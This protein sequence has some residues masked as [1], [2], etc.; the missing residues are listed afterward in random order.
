MKI[1]TKHL[2]RYQQIVRLLWKYGRSDLVK[3]LDD[4]SFAADTPPA[5]ADRALPD[6]LADD[7]E[8]MGPTYVKLGQVLSSR[9]D[10]IPATY[11]DALERLQDRVK[12]FSDAEA[13]QIIESELGAR[14]S[15]AFSRFDPEPIA[16]ASLGQVHRAALR[17]GR[18]VVVKVQRPN[19]GP[20]IA[21]DFE[22]LAQMSAFLDEHSDWARRRRLGQIV[23]ELR[24]SVLHELDYEREAQSMRMMLKNIEGFD[25]LY[26]PQP[27]DDYCT[28]RV[29]TMEY[30]AGTKITEL[31]P[32][33][34]MELNGAELAEQLFKAY[35]K[36]VLV[37]GLFHADPHPGNIFV[38]QDGHLVML[39][40]GMVG[41]VTPGM[42]EKLLKLLVAVS[43]GKSEQATD[44]V[45]QISEVGR[46]CDK[47][48]FQRI[49]G[50]VIAEQQGL[51][52]QQINVGKT[53]LDVTGAAA[54]NNVYVP[55]DL[56]LLAKTLLQLDEVGK[57]LDPKFD[58]NAS[59]R[60]NA[61]ELLSE[62][63]KKS[64]TQGSL[65]ST[66]LDLK[67]F[68]AGLPVRLNR[69]MDAITN[70]EV[71]VKVRTMDV[72][73]VLDGLQKVA[74]RITSGLILAA[75]IIGAALM[76]RVETS[77]QVF[78]YP[79]IAIL[80]FLGAAAGGVWL[81]MNIFIKDRDATRRAA[82]G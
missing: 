79:G 80:C 36:H 25:R 14:I 75:L 10:L 11:S 33:A 45:L 53:L 37:D 66:A 69:I 3:Q 35:L 74:N 17:D 8:A 12:P 18:E 50:K 6:Q 44:V 23:E 77:F 19:I 15:K 56:T 7:L 43:E 22:V 81:L 21:D 46:D 54:E 63:M 57:C 51:N 9:P 59:I 65:L 32:I 70:K 20:Q 60:R 34:R 16:A 68:L 78:G 42:Q 5:A 73:V 41:R 31:S 62:R 38:T 28:K 47:P 71:E 76:M 52:M 64:S 4:A 2:T 49:I 30:V 82:R 61:A 13:Q 26:V 58:P 67:D 1:N 72:D 48:A 24:V 29:L 40:L 39:D 27:I 55:S